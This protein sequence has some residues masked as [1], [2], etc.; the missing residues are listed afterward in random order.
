M[1]ELFAVIGA[2]FVATK[3]LSLTYSVLTGIYARFLRGGVK[4]TKYG[5]WAGQ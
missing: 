3:A 1:Q 4:V 5:Q 2:L